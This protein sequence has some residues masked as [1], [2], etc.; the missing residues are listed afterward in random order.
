M[1]RCTSCRFL[2]EAAK[3]GLLPDC[4]QCGGATTFVVRI[5]AGEPPP[6]QPTLKFAVVRTEAAGG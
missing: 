6:A 5:E 2:V 3:P 1:A 4:P